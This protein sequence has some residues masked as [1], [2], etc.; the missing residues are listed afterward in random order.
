MSQNSK[1][2]RDAKKKKKK[3]VPKAVRVNT[4]SE[5]PPSRPVMQ[6]LDNP[7]E[8]LSDEARKKA[9]AEISANSKARVEESLASIID[10]FKK[11]DPVAILAHFSMYG[12]TVGAG[13]D[14]VKTKESPIGVTQAHV[15]I[16]QAMML[17]I[18]AEELG[19]D[20]AT[21]EILQIV[22]DNITDLSRCYSNSRI[23]PALLDATKLEQAI[24]DIQETVRIHTQIVRNWGYHTQIL[25]IS[26]EIYS[27]FDEK[28]EAKFGFTAS[29]VIDVFKEHLDSL[30]IRL[31]KR[32][33]GLGEI[34]AQKKPKK[35]LSR[36]YDLNEDW[37][38]NDLEGNGADLYKHPPQV[39]F[40]LIMAHYDLLLRE[41]YKINE[42]ELIEKLKIK[43]DSL[44]KLLNYFSAQF[45]EFEKENKL[46]FFLDNPIW[47]KPIISTQHGYYCFMPQLF[48]SFVLNIL[49]SL[50]ES[51]DKDNLHSRRADYLESKIE[52]IVKRRF[53][54]SKVVSSLKWHQ[55]G[56]QFET[57]LVA[58]IDSYAIIIEAKAHKISNIALRGAPARIKRHLEDI[59]I[60]PGIQSRR[61]ELK[62]NEL[63]NSKNQDDLLLSK[64]PV[65]INSIHKI[66]R[67]SI[68]LEYFASLQANLKVFDDTGWIPDEFIPCP[69]MNIADFETLFDFLEHPVHI[70]HYLQRRTE[71]EPV[72]NIHGDELDY[73]GFYIST[74]FD[75]GNTDKESDLILSDMSIPLD[76]Y[77]MSKDQGIK[78]PKPQPQISPF[79]KSILTKLEQRAIPRWS[80]IGCI[81]NYFPPYDQVK[82]VRA[83]KDLSFVVKKN[84]QIEGHKNMLIYV[85]AQSSEYAL[86]IVLYKNENRDRRNEFIQQAAS[87]GVEPDHVKSCLVI[88]INIDK[89]DSPYHTIGLF[90]KSR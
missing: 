29:N 68:S 21:P 43:A 13:D 39:M 15:E 57:D 89:N 10:I 87:S 16:L 34:K 58:F 42:S 18:P 55:G 53:P 6:R 25:T 73:M 64:L 22:K 61:F 74:L 48:F 4:F 36:Y 62:L 26:K 41:E 82:I 7:F 56:Q 65:D 14:G 19:I 23:D 8:G 67:V 72:Y 44:N 52:E 46:Y 37:N 77:Y 49:D 35:M 81:L 88:S 63:R 90:D 66:I 83:I 17:S 78:I 5:L 70:I 84:W 80:E 50:I 45:G 12:L 24:R 2:K 40:M 27:H 79:F 76:R 28:L 85:P 30:E 1:F 75:M 86:A 69:S 33:S 71:T 54:E 20:L 51:I 47:S 11:H 60:E 31:S 59:L 9:M 38:K 32:W 3:I